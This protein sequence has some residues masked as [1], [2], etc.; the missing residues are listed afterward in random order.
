MDG[1]FLLSGEIGDIDYFGDLK[2]KICWNHTEN[3]VLSR[4][5]PNYLDLSA[6]IGILR[7]KVKKQIILKTGIF[8]SVARSV[9]KSAGG[10]QEASRSHSWIDGY[11][12]RVIRLLRVYAQPLQSDRSL[13]ST[14]MRSGADEPSLLLGCGLTGVTS[15][16]IRGWWGWGWWWWIRLFFS[17]KNANF[18]SLSPSPSSSSSSSSTSLCVFKAQ[19][20]ADLPEWRQDPSKYISILPPLPRLCFEFSSFH[21]CDQAVFF[22]TA[23]NS[24]NYKESSI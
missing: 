11:H 1:V 8:Y 6:S 17:A 7:L 24:F 13:F 23:C 3:H 5:L 10:A 16:V 22:T 20:H 19:Q 2:K 4:I 12:Q 18:Y 9:P 15:G 21:T 14:A